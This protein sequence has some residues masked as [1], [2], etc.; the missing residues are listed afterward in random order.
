MRQKRPCRICC[1]WFRPHP[2][3]GPRQKVCSSAACQRERHRRACRVWHRRNPDYDRESRF[4]RKLRCQQAEAGAAALAIN[5]GRQLAWPAARDVVGL[6]VVVLV[7]EV[8]RLLVRWARDAVTAQTS[9]SQV[10]TSR[11]LRLPA[12]DEIATAARAP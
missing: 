5:P 9:R 3:V 10:V 6:E 4:R 2:R 1:R 12:R 8:L 11:H 7:E